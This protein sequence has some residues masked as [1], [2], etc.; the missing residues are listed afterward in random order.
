MD[1]LNPIA[2]SVLQ[3]P[4]AQRQAAV[5]KGKQLQRRDRARRD[6]DPGA[7]GLEPTVES[8]DEVAAIRREQADDHEKRR[9]RPAAY[10]AD[11]TVEDL[12]EGDGVDL[13]A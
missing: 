13:T 10:R 5:E 4:M 7:D 9:R 12:E 11:G 3:T 8:P 1:F 6:S 2:P